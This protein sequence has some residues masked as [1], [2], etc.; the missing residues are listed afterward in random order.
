MSVDDAIKRMRG[1]AGTSVKLTIARAN[2]LK[3]IQ[4]V[5]KRAKISLKSVKRA[6]LAPNYGYIRITNFQADTTNQLAE[7]LVKLAKDNPKLKGLVLDLR[8][9]PGGIL[10]SAVGVSSAFLA[11]NSLI[12]YTKGRVS[13]A[14]QK[15][16]AKASDYDINGS[17]QQA[18]DKIPAMFKTIPMVVLVN[19]GTASASE[20]VSGALQD[21]QRA[22]VI[23]TR[24]FGKGSVQTLIPISATTA[25]KLTTALYYTPNGRS[26]QA[27]GIKP[28]IIVQSEYSDLLNSWDLS[29]ANLDKHINNPNQNKS[30]VAKES[31]V[32][33]IRPPKQIA[34]QAELDAKLDARL[35]SVP[36][37]VNQEQAQIDLADD[38]QLKW[39]LNILEGKPLPQ[40][41]ESQIKTT[42]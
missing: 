33:V 15:Y 29:E 28:N 41:S 32:P 8:D 24:T 16:F 30:V 26:I 21:Y 38:F 7:A 36:N 34:T 1:K 4:L 10:Q 6:V 2:E 42:K 5:V 37:V 17:Q 11:P 9:D 12:V 25:I 40:N 27:E 13:E 20:I 19:Q 18:L 14:Q 35:K 23:G 3:P 31:S 22:K 39:A